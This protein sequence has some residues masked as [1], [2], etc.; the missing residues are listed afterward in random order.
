MW[1]T[2]SFLKRC[3]RLKQLGYS[4]SPKP[5]RFIARGFADLG[6][7]VFCVLPGQ[8]IVSL[9]TGEKASFPE[10]DKEHYFSVPSVDDIAEELDRREL[11]FALQSNEGRNWTVNVSSD[12][13]FT[14]R[15]LEE[16]MVEAFI[17]VLRRES[18]SESL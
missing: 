13:E 1:A 17:S 4:V 3:E 10:S 5:S 7:E 2:N 8:K 12:E 9:F 15:T 14:E 16:A 11:S 6:Y 18:D